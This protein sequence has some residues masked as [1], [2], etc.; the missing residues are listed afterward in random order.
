MLTANDASHLCLPLLCSLAGNY[1][2]VAGCKAVA[3]VLDKTQITSLKCAKP[4]PPSAWTLHGLCVYVLAFASA[5]FDSSHLCACPL[6]Y[7]LEGTRPG[8]DGWKVVAA[9]LDKTQITSLKCAS[10]TLPS[11]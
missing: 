5:A 7:S 3:A 10:H 11:A 1:L 2:G 9:V 4:T 6:L 8:A